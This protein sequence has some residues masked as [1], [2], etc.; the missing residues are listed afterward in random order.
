MNAAKT[1]SPEAVHLLLKKD[2]SNGD[3]VWADPNITDEDGVTALAFSFNTNNAQVINMLAEVTTEAGEAT[4]KMLAQANVR[5]EAELEIYVKKI[6]NDGQIEKGKILE[7]STF[8]TCRWS[9]WQ[10]RTRG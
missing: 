9:T 10:R 3:K 1:S 6:L 5:I 4:M 7:L 8:F 2:S